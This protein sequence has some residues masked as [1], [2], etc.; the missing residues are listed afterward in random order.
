[1]RTLI[2]CLAASLLSSEGSARAVGGS[3]DYLLEERDAQI[4]VDA[5]ARSY[6]RKELNQMA[7]KASTRLRS[8]SAP[9]SGRIMMDGGS[10]QHVSFIFGP[11]LATFSDGQALSICPKAP[12]DSKPGCGL[13]M[14]AGFGWELTRT[15][16][17]DSTGN[18]TG[19]ECTL[20]TFPY[21]WPVFLNES[22]GQRLPWRAAPPSL[23]VTESH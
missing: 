9:I 2:F 13:P 22:T 7:K 11:I 8:L 3:C 19:Y 1:M 10:W 21:P 12:G 4:D 15:N 14:E 20:K 17:V 23:H 5:V 6:L 18:V 16:K